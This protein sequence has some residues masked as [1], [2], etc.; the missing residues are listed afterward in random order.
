MRGLA[1]EYRDRV[2]VLII[3]VDHASGRDR[4]LMRRIGSRVVP[5]FGFFD[6]R[7]DVVGRLEGWNA[8]RFRQ[9]LED[10]LSV[11]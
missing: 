8:M 3:D 10:L 6:R 1:E 7:G 5:A 9:A 2:D 11:P 4:E